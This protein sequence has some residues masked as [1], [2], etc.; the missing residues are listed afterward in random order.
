MAKKAVK[1]DNSLGPILI[2]I[3]LLLTIGTVIGNNPIADI[4][5]PILGISGTPAPIVAPQEKNQPN[6]PPADNP[7][8]IN[9]GSTEPQQTSSGSSS[10]VES[11]LPQ[12]VG[13]AVI[14]GGE[15]QTI[16]LE[17]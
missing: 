2:A 6:I 8:P 13:S 16:A 15:V 9:V 12:K 17:R 1:R 14:L 11:N 3:G 10:A 5:R 4:I 7:Q